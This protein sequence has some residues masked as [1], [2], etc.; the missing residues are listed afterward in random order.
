MLEIEHENQYQYNEDVLNWLKNNNSPFFDWIIIIAFYTSLHKIDQCL[1]KRGF[2]D[3][4][5]GS[6]IKRNNLV[7]NNLPTT[8]CTEYIKLYSKSRVVR[9][10]QDTL[11]DIKSEDLQD[12]LDIWFKTIKPFN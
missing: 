7:I 12:Y 8:I 5:I 9:Y 11:Y 3:F 6:H 2:N 4:Q 10:K 1:H